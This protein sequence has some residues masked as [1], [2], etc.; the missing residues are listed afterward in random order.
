MDGNVEP[1]QAAVGFGSRMRGHLDKI[2]RRNAG[3]VEQVA[4]RLLDCV[5]GGWLVFAAGSGHSLGAVNETFYRAGGLACVRPL[6]V[7]ELLPLHGAYASTRAERR[8]GIARRVLD[9]TDIGERD[10]LI[11]FSN[12]G[13]NPYPVEMAQHARRKGCDVVAVTSTAAM[14]AA[15]PRSDGTLADHATYLLDTL[16]PPGDA[17]YPADA[18]RTGPLSSLA[19]AYLWNLLL[20]DL[21]ARAARAGVELPLWGSTNATGNESSN[22]ALLA[23]YAPRIP[24]LTGEREDHSP[25]AARDP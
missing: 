5:A 9:G 1:A 20:S 23:R 11:V 12:S 6:Y 15:P 4:D 16:V 10:V 17:A 19:N 18:P 13:V 22:E 21:V 8:S 7:P 2:E 24:E 14:A 3:H 25:A